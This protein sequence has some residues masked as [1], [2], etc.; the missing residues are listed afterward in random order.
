MMHGAMP[1]RPSLSVVLATIEPWPDLANC[2]EVLLPQVTAIGGELL[3]GDGD[4]SALE[5]RHLAEHPCLKLIRLPGASVFELRAKALELAQGELIATTEDHCLVASDWCAQIQHAFAQHPDVLAVTG[6]VLNGS[7]DHLIDWANYL[8]NFGSTLPPFDSPERWY[9]APPCVNIAYRRSVL[10]AGPVPPGWM[11]LEVNP[12]LLRDG[13]FLRHEAMTV[14]HVQS[15]GLWGTM[16]THFHNGR[17]TT[18]LHPERFSGNLLPWRRFRATVRGFSDGAEYRAII[19]KSLP[20]VF[21]LTCC[22]A[23]GETVGI[24]AGPGESPRRLR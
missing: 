11:E 15:H 20:L 19:R 17:T 5:E 16:A 14:T 21:L 13:G 18:G 22:H 24:V 3:V 12:R 10:P 6:P 2:L 9:R 23:L 1:E 8:H 4:G 7:R